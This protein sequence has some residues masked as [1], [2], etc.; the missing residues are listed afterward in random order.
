VSNEQ[1]SAVARSYQV[2]RLTAEDPNNLLT[3][4]KVTLKSV[5]QGTLIIVIPE[6]LKI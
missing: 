1:P 2:V 4:C 6:I 5:L 3:L